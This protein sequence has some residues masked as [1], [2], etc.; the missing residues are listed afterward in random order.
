MFK[1]KL[2]ID[3]SVSPIFCKAR[4]VPFLLKPRIEQAIDRNVKEEIW[5]PVQY[6]EWAAPIVPIQKADGTVRL[7]GDYKV[8]CNKASQIDKYPIPSVKDIFTKLAGRKTFTKIDLSQAYSQIPVQE[9]SLK[10][11]T[12]NTHKGLFKLTRLP[13]GISSAPGIS[14]A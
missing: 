12:V 3:N 7:C 2:A 14:N 6:S 11:L 9:E 5:E 4:S 1:Y 13:F 10:Y 8:T